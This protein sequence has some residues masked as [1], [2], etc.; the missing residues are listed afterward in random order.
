MSQTTRTKLYQWC[1]LLLCLVGMVGSAVAS[2]AISIQADRL[3]V[4]GG[5]GTKFGVI[6]SVTANQIYIS[7]A[8]QSGW[9]RI[10]FDHR[11]GWVSSQYIA[12]INQK[13]K[14]VKVGS[15]NVRSGSSTRFRAVGKT[16]KNAEWAIMSTVDGWDKIY[17]GGNA[18]WIY[19]QFLNNSAPPRPPKSS[20]GFI[21]LPATGKGFYSTKPAKRSWGLPRL[22]YGLQKS[23]RS[24]HRDH[25]NWGKI[26]IGDLSLK[27][28]GYM[29]GHASHQRGMDVDIRLI[30][31]DG[32]A[33]GTTIYKQ[34]YSS[35]RNLNYIKKYL[36]QYF[37]VDLIFFNDK[38]VFSM[39]P[40]SYGKRYGDCRRKPGASG[41]AYVMCWP[42]HHDHFHLRIK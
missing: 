35:K 8:S 29:S 40:S 33:K 39:L 37:D 34:H 9:R 13:S 2:Q 21:Q 25:P 41:V 20:A 14:K 24:W 12:T 17:Y 6:G 22:V 23:S 28:G 7:I 19:G 36:K 30:R 3:N 38:K 27:K 31:K 4:R 16:S 11:T 1:A 32:A 18:R 42:N 15:L 26:G 5:P 10:W